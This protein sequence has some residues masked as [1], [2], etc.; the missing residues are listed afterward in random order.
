M[1][2]EGKYEGAKVTRGCSSAHTRNEVPAAD[3]AV[4]QQPLSMEVG[5][6]LRVFTGGESGGL[7]SLHPLVP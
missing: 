6:R 1:L 3:S 7:P 2:Q 5:L 4:G